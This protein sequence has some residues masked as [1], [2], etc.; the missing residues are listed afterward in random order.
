MFIYQNKSLKNYFWQ[1]YPYLEEDKNEIKSSNNLPEIVAKILAQKKITNIDD[2][3]NPALKSAL[4]TPFPLKDIEKAARC[5]MDACFNAKKI[6]I[7]GDY[8]VDGATSSAL[9]KNFLAQ[10]GIEADIY[11]P[12]RLTEGYGPNEK[13]FLQLKQNGT[14]L[15]ITVDCGIVAFEPIEAA[16]KLDMDIIIIDHH[17][18]LETLPKADAIVNP[19]RL[20]ESGDYKYLAGVGVTFLLLIALNYLLEKHGFYVKHN[21][22]KPNLLQFIDLV[23]LGTVCDIVPLI[24]LN[25]LFVKHG[26]KAINHTKNL[27]L[28]SLITLSN[29]EQVSSYHLGFILG[30]MINAG[31]RIGESDLGS[32]LL[33]ANDETSCQRDCKLLI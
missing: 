19:N 32:R 10:I 20:D 1:F 5:V 28:R 22:E 11:I 33:S 25:R 31:G 7:F 14:D 2:F 23:A 30:P 8:D 3:L 12:N 17:L 21:R 13:A 16:K 26:L 18:S 4:K 9:L 27:G 15:I 6:T 29:L 24:G